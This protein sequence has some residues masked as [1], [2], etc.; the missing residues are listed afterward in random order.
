MDLVELLRP[1]NIEYVENLAWVRH[2]LDHTLMLGD[3]EYLAKT[4]LTMLIFRKINQETK[5]MQIRHQRSSDVCFDTFQDADSKPDYTYELIETFL[6]LSVQQGRML[7]LWGKPN[8]A[9][10]TGWTKVVEVKK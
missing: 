5:K 1:H 6:P 7:E 2:N 9:A 3:Y 10:R 4:K 8:I